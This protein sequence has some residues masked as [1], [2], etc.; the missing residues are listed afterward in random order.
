MTTPRRPEEAAYEFPEIWDADWFERD[1][2]DR[3]RLLAGLLPADARTLLDVGC[4]GGLFLT[5]LQSAHS[6]R[7]SRLCGVDRSRAGA[8]SVKERGVVASIDRLPWPDASFDVVSCLEVLEHLPAAIYS[9]AIQELTRVA[10]RYL[11]VSVPYRQDLVAMHCRCPECLTSFHPDYHM[12]SFHEETLQTLFTAH[13]FQT[14]GVHYLGA[15]VERYDHA[16]RN[17]LRAFLRGRSE[18]PLEPSFPAYAI[19]P[20]CGFHDRAALL[21]ELQRRRSRSFQARLPEAVAPGRLRSLLKDRLPT[22][23]SY[24]W[25]AAV[26]ERFRPAGPS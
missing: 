16:F 7:F 21:D 14:T 12:R 4:G 5:H 20:A 3:V 15:Q 23:V 9:R 1:D 11:L 17:R 2:H 8:A 26:F 24:R 19:C 25:I 6:G 13:G 22:R 10:G 18:R